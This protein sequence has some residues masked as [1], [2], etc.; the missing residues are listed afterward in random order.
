MRTPAPIAMPELSRFFGIVIR[1]F[2]EAGAPHHRAH[3]YAFYQEHAA[4]VFAIDT[5][6]CLDGSLPKSAAAARRGLGR[7]PPRGAAARLG[8]LAIWSAASQDRSTQVIP[9]PIRSI[10]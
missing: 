3:F 7:D 1:M 8:A 5:I 4:A 10:A 6:E 9:C 2:V